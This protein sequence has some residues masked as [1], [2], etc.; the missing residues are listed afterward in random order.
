MD[1]FTATKYKQIL[2]AKKPR[3]NMDQLDKALVEGL[4]SFIIYQNVLNSKEELEKEINAYLTKYNDNTNII[5]S[6]VE[7][8]ENYGDHGFVTYSS[9][10]SLKLI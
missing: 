10:V 7:T 1:G 6:N 4:E 8:L 2:A 3:V 9:K 5:V